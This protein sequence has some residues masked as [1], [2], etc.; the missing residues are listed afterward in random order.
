MANDVVLIRYAVAAMHIT[1][2]AGNIQCLAGV[3]ALHHGDSF[4]RG[5]SLVEQTAKLQATLQAQGDL[6]LH[7][8]QFFL[9]QL[10]GRQGTSELYAFEGVASCPVPTILRRAEHPPRDTV[11]CPV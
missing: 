11:A 2:C 8:G 1:R 9:N 3:V 6:S 5:R 10:V 4:R 7:V